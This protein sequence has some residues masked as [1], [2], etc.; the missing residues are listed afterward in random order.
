[1]FRYSLLFAALVGFASFAHAQTRA[2][3]MFD[4]LSRDFGSVPRGQVVMHPF[5]FVNKSDQPVRIS[6]VTVSCGCTHAYAAKMYLKPGEESAIIA[7][8]NT[9]PFLNTRTVTIYVTFD[10]PRYQQVRLWVQANSREDVSFN[11]GSIAFGQVKR[12]EERD[13]KVV[14]SFL[15]GQTQITD[16]KSESNYV[17]PTI[18]EASRTSNAAAYEIVAKLRK[19]TPPGKWYTDVWLSTNNP[20]MPKLRVPVTVEVE[21]TLSVNPSEISLG[22]IKAGTEEDRRVIIRGARP[23]RITGIT[24]SDERLQVRTTTNESKSVHILTV[25]LSPLEPGTTLR[26]TITVRTDLATGGDIRFNATAEVVP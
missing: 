16:I 15:G 13:S 19:D 23:F 1:M 24:G 9:Q 26:G 20:S 14:I 12:G 25:T 5:R 10:Q 18:R 8:M 11:P 4:E 2:D 6:S 3:G 22:K 17:T 7:E 21:A